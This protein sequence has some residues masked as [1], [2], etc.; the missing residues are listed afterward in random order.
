MAL[1][2]A[3]S[4]FAPER[5]PELDIALHTGMRRSEQYSCEWSWVDLESR[6][7]TIPRS[8]HGEKRR[9]YLNDA[10]VAAFSLWSFSEEERAGVPAHLYRSSRTVG[11]RGWFEQALG[12]AKIKN[13][14]W[15]DLR[16]RTPVA[17]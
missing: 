14:R 1:R 15:H 7:V 2:A 16:Q 6:V 9:V 17:L 5:F 8:K 3:L 13:F 4:E 10:A 12:A 11:A